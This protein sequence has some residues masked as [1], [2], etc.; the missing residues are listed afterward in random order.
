MG[1]CR[2][3]KQRMSCMCYG[4]PKTNKKLLKLYRCLREL[5]CTLGDWKKEKCSKDPGC[6]R[7]CKRK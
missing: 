6:K 4:S 3:F 2:D 7:K 1:K 5:D